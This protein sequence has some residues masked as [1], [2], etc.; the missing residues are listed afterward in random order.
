MLVAGLGI[1]WILDGLEVTMMGAVG[2]VLQRP[3][4]MHFSA[5]Q[6]GFISSCYLAGAVL[7][8]LVF[9][10]L[11]DQFGRRLFFFL[12]LIIYLIGVGFSA[13]S[14]SLPSFALFRFITGVGIGGEYSA[15]RSTRRSTN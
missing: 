12:S 5:A 4:V 8:A 11:T 3:D 6:V 13:L 15:P 14:W 7:G 9:G 1:T 10:H 2:A